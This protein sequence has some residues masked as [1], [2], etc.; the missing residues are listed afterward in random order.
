M[1]KHISKNIKEDAH[2]VVS[3]DGLKLSKAQKERI[4][5]GI[6]ELVMKEIA[7]IDTKGDLVINQKLGL[8]PKLP[9]NIEW[10]GIW[11]E[12]FNRRFERVG[13]LNG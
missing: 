5:N 11:I 3:L 2:F 10:F 7:A 9:R 8:N 1:E 6:K 13:L 4:D 12:N